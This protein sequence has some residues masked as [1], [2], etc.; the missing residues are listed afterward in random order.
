[1]SLAWIPYLLAMLRSSAVR[2]MLRDLY[3][4]TGGNVQ[5][6]NQVVRRMRSRGYQLVEVEREIDHDLDL[7]EQRQADGAAGKPPRGSA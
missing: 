7:L 6:S 3:N 5:Q 1:M 2:D 4:L